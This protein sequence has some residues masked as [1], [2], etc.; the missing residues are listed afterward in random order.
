MVGKTQSPWVRQNPNVRLGKNPDSVNAGSL[1]V[2]VKR[3]VHHLKGLKHA[4]NEERYKAYSNKDFRF[5]RK[6]EKRKTE[7][8][9][10]QENCSKHQQ[11][12]LH[13]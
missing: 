8:L 12:K 3:T 7:T 5:P 6:I 9:S 11:R 10:K 2:T 1:R 4:R 13:L